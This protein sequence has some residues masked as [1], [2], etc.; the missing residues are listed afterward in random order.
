MRHTNEATGRSIR[1]AP[2]A[3]HDVLP[4]SAEPADRLR[5]LTA[6]ITAS[7]SAAWRHGRKLP[8]V[9]SLRGVAILLVVLFHLHAMV[10]RHSFA[11]P[12][13]G[14]DRARDGEPASLPHIAAVR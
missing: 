8:E 6:P 5:R 7:A 12:A 3:A 4:P 14:F 9:E 1:Q 13:D 2:L 11:T 10:A